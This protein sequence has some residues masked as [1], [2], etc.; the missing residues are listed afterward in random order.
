MTEPTVA[1]WSEEAPP[2]SQLVDTALRG[3]GLNPRW[4]S[5]GPGDVYT[6]HEHGYHKVLFCAKG[7]ITF[8]TPAGEYELMSGD[9]LE[10]PAGTRHSAVVGDDGVECVEAER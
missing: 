8:A 6:S 1:R 10:L 4:W 2:T 5:N 3:E 7:S 9:R